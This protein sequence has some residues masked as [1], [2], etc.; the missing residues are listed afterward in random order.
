MSKLS[1]RPCVWAFSIA[2]LTSGARSARPP[3]CRAAPSGRV[4]RSRAE[5]AHQVVF[6]GEEEAR[7]SRGRPD[8]RR[9]RAAGCRCG[10]S[11]GARCR[12]CAG[13]RAA[14]DLVLL[15]GLALDSLK[16][17]RAAP[18]NLLRAPCRVSIAARAGASI[19]GVAAEQ[20]VGTAAGHVGGDRD[21][22][23]C[24]RPG[25]RCRPRARAAW[26]SARRAGCPRCV[27]HARGRPPTSRR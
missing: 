7:A 24:G 14:I 1:P 18:S 3:P 22:A 11:R 8:G 15:L 2:A 20:D 4:M 10:G 23:A 6:E 19:S 13:R 21:G 25:R 27:E 17:A 9:G 16:P 5:D 12:R 26:R